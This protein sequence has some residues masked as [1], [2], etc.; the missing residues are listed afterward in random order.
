MTPDELH[1]RRR[2]DEISKHAYYFVAACLRKSI[3]GGADLINTTQKSI[4]NHIKWLE[5]FRGE[6]LILPTAPGQT[7]KLT[8]YG[9]KFWKRCQTDFTGAIRELDA[10]K[11]DDIVGTSFVEAIKTSECT[12]RKPSD[13][14]S[15]SPRRRSL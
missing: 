8:P 10:E 14:T 3:M 9:T 15:S 13:P 1:D 6:K 7:M 12:P 5:K 4:F 2:F 11:K